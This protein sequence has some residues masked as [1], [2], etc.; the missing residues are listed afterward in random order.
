MEPQTTIPEDDLWGSTAPPAAEGAEPR[1]TP[2]RRWVVA[3]VGA[4]AIGAGAVAGA[5]LVGS[6][7]ES[8]GAGGAAGRGQGGFGGGNGGG[9][10][11]TIAS[12]DGTTLRMTTL[13]GGTV[14]VTTSASTAVTVSTTGTL[15]DVK[16]GD[17]VQVFG[18]RAGLTVAA[19]QLIDGGTS[20]VAEGPAGG[21]SGGPQPSAPRAGAAPPAGDARTDDGRDGAEMNG[22]VKS[23]GGGTLIVATADGT[24][25]TITTTSSTAVLVVREGTVG[26]LEVGDQIQ[27]AGPTSEGTITATSIRAGASVAAPGRGG[28]RA[29]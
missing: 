3:I 4:A 10:G 23:Q 14:N 9:N 21:P 20:P 27:V 19:T 16:V 2:L 11:G 8:A 12:I 24:T 13:A 22:V 25:L 26:S 15:G 7:T 5:S 18:T 1:K 29:P 17:N 28:N 6:S